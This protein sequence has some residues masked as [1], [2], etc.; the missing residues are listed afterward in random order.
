M[1]NSVPYHP[2]SCFLLSVDL[3]NLHWLPGVCVSGIL[4]VIPIEDQ[5]NLEIN[6][7]DNG[8]ML[9]VR[10]KEEL[11]TPMIQMKHNNCACLGIK[12]FSHHC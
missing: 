10:L 5:E 4:L 1:H 2:L 7:Q 8:L 6:W 12:L 9:P 3:I 11:T